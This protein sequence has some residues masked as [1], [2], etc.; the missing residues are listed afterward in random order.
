MIRIAITEAAFEAIAQTLP[1]GS[2][3]Y[4]KRDQREGRAPDLARSGGPRPPQGDARAGRGQQRRDPAAGRLASLC[5]ECTFAL[6]EPPVL[7]EMT[8]S[9]IGR[10][11]VG[12]MQGKRPREPDLDS[13]RAG[14]AGIGLSLWRGAPQRLR[15]WRV[16]AVIPIGNPDR[17]ITRR[18]SAFFENIRVICGRPALARTSRSTSIRA[19]PTID[20]PDD[21][22]AA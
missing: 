18:A 15:R 17:R 6:T 4:E 5:V 14:L 19:V 13:G 7:R 20:L 2:V 11:L 8:P 9:Q 3:G 21:E 1:L 22:L 16:G 10:R 12:L